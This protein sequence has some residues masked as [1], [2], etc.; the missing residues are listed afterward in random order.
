MTQVDATSRRAAAALRL[1]LL[2]G[3]FV[4]AGCSDPAPGDKKDNA[5]LKTSMQ[6]SMEIYKSKPQAKKGNPP[7]F[8]RPH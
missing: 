6:K 7:T 2:A 4:I 8:K 5:A 3:F 1:G